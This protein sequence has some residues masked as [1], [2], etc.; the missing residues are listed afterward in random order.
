LGTAATRALIDRGA[1]VALCD[2]D[3]TS[4]LNALE[5]IGEYADKLR[6]EDDHHTAIEH[7]TLIFD[8]TNT[9]NFI[10]PSHLSSETKMAAPGMPCALTPEAMAQHRDHVIHDALEIGTATMIILAAASIAAR[11]NANKVNEA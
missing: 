4:V 10:E 6:V 8:A 11:D 7:Y 3:R 9:G 1:H 5:E 2:I